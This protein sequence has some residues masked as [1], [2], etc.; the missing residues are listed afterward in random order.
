[1]FQV[2]AEITS[3]TRPN[4][5]VKTSSTISASAISRATGNS[6]VSEMRP[7]LT[8]MARSAWRPSVSFASSTPVRVARASLWRAT[9]LPTNITRA[10]AI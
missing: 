10:P 7:W 1:M 8:S 9:A 6:T 3:R 5:A 4:R 2:Q